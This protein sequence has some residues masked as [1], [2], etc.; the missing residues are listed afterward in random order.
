[1]QTSS[2]S[3]SFTGEKTALGLYLFFDRSIPSIRFAFYNNGSLVYD[4]TRAQL[5]M[6]ITS[7]P[8]LTDG[9]GQTTGFKSNGF[10]T[11]S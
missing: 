7:G 2:E 3:I 5:K 11:F 6:A 9:G 4:L 10:V 1:M 8:K